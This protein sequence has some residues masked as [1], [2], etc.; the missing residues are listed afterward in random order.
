MGKYVVGV[1]DLHLRVIL[2]SNVF[3]KAESDY[4]PALCI[5]VGPVSYTHLDVYKRQECN[6]IFF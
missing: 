2:N 6:V 4:L 5:A 3:A 1:S